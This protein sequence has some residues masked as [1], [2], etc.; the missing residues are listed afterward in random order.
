M[1]G[2]D[3]L[4]VVLTS[5]VQA[6]G[7]AA[8]LN[9]MPSELARDVRAQAE[10]Q[11]ARGGGG[12]LEAAAHLR[13]TY[14]AAIAERPRETG[15]L[16]LLDS[17]ARSHGPVSRWAASALSVLV[18]DL[19]EDTEPDEDVELRTPD[20][21]VAAAV[22]FLA[23]YVTACAQSGGPRFNPRF[24]TARWSAAS[25]FI[26]V[27]LQ[28]RLADS[29][30]AR[31]AGAAAEGQLRMRPGGPLED[32]LEP[33]GGMLL[34]LLTAPAAA[35]LAAYAPEPAAGWACAELARRMG[36]PPA[37]LEAVV[38]AVVAAGGGGA[39]PALFE[40]PRAACRAIAA[41]AGAGA[42]VMPLA[43]LDAVLAAAGAGTLHVVSP[44]QDLLL[45]L[46]AGGD[47]LLLP[48][49]HALPAGRHELGAV[50]LRL[51]S[52]PFLPR[53]GDGG[54]SESEGARRGSLIG[55]G[56]GRAHRAMIAAAAR[57]AAPGAATLRGGGGQATMRVGAGG[58][59]EAAALELDAVR[60][61]VEGDGASLALVGCQ[62]RNNVTDYDVRAPLPLP[63]HPTLCFG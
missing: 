11:V 23:E 31:L 60:L 52:A 56:E 8:G 37:D 49:N 62:L 41:A 54:W 28:Q 61:H 32:A 51:W 5:D 59:L 53:R 3:D 14:L 46:K 47:L 9:A 12:E 35:V 50:R 4:H 18:R 40:L 45:H 58:Q 15:Q 21:M 34:A 42:G 2:H 17:Q 36:V 16:L 20:W 43:D 27:G 25:F 24:T 38:A 29:L 22:E 19:T 63:R 48:G 44:E 10:E 26:A 1:H 33:A 55:R 57:S 39:L 13:A 7:A 30:S 6:E